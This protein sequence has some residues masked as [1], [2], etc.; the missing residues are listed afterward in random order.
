VH[1]RLVF[2]GMLY[3]TQT[4]ALRGRIATILER[5][6]FESLTILFSSEGGSTDQ[7][8]ALYN[9]LRA[10]PL[11]VHMH[12]VGHIGSASVPVFL[13]GHRRTC[14]PFARF[15]FH[16]YDWG[17]EGR[18]MSD[19]IAEALQRLRSD[20]ALSRQIAERHTSLSSERLD[21][22]YATSPTP[23]IFTPEEARQVRI[24]EEVL[25][26]NPTGAAQANVALWTVGW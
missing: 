22:L 15:F 23:T 11:P 1:Y 2:N 8:L 26:L 3:E 18:Q 14:T 6:D 17:F 16:A 25:E 9:F 5:Q 21:Q 10:L 13:G 20:I 24:V 7:S 4:N 19:R 12:G